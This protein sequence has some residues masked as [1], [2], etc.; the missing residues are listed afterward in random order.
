MTGCQGLVCVRFLGQLAAEAGL[1]MEE[2]PTFEVERLGLF[3]EPSLK[4]EAYSLEHWL[5]LNA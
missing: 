5:D 4:E 1:P 3:E 2:R